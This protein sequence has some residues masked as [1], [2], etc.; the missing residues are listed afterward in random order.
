MSLAQRLAMRSAEGQARLQEERNARI[1]DDNAKILDW[2]MKAMQEVTMKCEEAADAGKVDL[3]ITVSALFLRMQELGRRECQ[4]ILEEQLR[5]SGLS[6][7]KCGSV[8]TDII[9]QKHVF[10]CTTYVSWQD[11]PVVQ[12][13][14]NGRQHRHGGHRRLCHLCEEVGETVAIAPCGHVVCRGCQ[15]QLRNQLCPFCRRHVAS[16][17]DVLFSQT[18][19][20]R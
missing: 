3:R 9:N 20:K 13:A 11:I 8:C 12:P 19:L 14:D 5:Q 7:V 4:D 15:G 10:R 18:S 16:F 6:K 2:A 17:T 1:A